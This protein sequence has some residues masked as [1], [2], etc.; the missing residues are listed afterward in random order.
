MARR[1][2]PRPSSLR[3]ALQ[4]RPASPRPALPRR[5]GGGHGHARAG[6][7]ARTLRPRALPGRRARPRVHLRRLRRLCL[8]QGVDPGRDLAGLQERAQDEHRRVAGQRG[9]RGAVVAARRPLPPRAPACPAQRSAAAPRGCTQLPVPVTL[10]HASACVSSTRRPGQRHGP[11]QPAD[12]RAGEP[13]RS[14]AHQ[15][16]LRPAGWVVTSERL[17]AAARRGGRAR[18]GLP[19]VARAA[20]PRPTALL[21]PRARAAVGRT[22]PARVPTCPHPSAGPKQSTQNNASLCRLRRQRDG[23]RDHSVAPAAEP[24]GGSRDGLAAAHRARQRLGAGAGLWLER[25]LPGCCSD[26]AGG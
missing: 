14:G 18:G 24:A 11:H 15:H 7:R 6:A 13:A 8:L 21:C 22:W 19:P 16:A 12:H 2:L 1:A 5:V 17:W 9:L 4:P 10:E 20:A 23:Q 25:A 3:P 26:Q